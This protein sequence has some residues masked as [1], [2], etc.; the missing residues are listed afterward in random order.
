M[1]VQS[2]GEYKEYKQRRSVIVI[3]VVVA[4]YLFLPCL[5][6][7]DSSY[8]LSYMLFTFLWQVDKTKVWVRLMTRHG[9]AWHSCYLTQIIV[10]LPSACLFLV[11]FSII[12][13]AFPSLFFIII[14]QSMAKR[15]KER[16]VV[17]THTYELL[18]AVLFR[19]VLFHFWLTLNPQLGRS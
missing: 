9:I 15:V 1:A 7:Q 16:Q 12:H 2:H 11:F 3:I 10:V 4:L 13:Q 5:L 14:L 17:P 6:Q 8:S 18:S 19:C